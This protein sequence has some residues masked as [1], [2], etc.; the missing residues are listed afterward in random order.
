MSEQIVLCGRAKDV[1]G[2]RFGRLVA[3]RPVDRSSDGKIM[4][5]CRCDCGNLTTVRSTHLAAGKT[6]S[7]RCL[8]NE[9]ARQR[10]TT[11]GL[12]NHRV[13]SIW[14]HALDR[15]INPND[16]AYPDYGG[17]GITMLD[18]WRRDF[19]AFYDYVTRLPHY[20]ELDRTLDRIDNSLGY[21]PNNLRWATPV[22]QSRNRRYNRLLTFD[23]RTQCL[24]AWAEEARMPISRLTQ[25][26][27]LGWP[28]EKALNTP[29]R[30]M[31]R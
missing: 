30:G 17:R 20:E 18:E 31:P 2:Q 3:L 28:L 6:L 29:K 26:L 23:G 10:E 15:C 14:H 22:E 1:T 13:Y 11:H 21:Q 4:W 8:A 7:C 12:R 25:R 19:Q 5:L 9:L 24:S 27:R 16:A